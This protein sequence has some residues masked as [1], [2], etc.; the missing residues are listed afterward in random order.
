MIEM[1]SLKLKNCFVPN[2]EIYVLKLKIKNMTLHKTSN[3]SL[4]FIESMHATAFLHGLQK[5]FCI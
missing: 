5:I 4:F 1:I 3:N 2:R